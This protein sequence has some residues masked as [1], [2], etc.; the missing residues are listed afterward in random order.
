MRRS[1]ALLVLCLIALPAIAQQ[2]KRPPDPT[3]AQVEA[4]LPAGVR[5]TPERFA[6]ALRDAGAKEVRYMMFDNESHG[7][8]QRQ[9]LLTYPAMKAFFDKALAHR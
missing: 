6:K 7:V 3:A 8:F 5:Y 2:R 1:I 4:Q 9:Q